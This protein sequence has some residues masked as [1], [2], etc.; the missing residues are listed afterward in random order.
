VCKVRAAI[1]A[2]KTVAAPVVRRERMDF[3]VNMEEKLG[4]ACGE[5]YRKEKKG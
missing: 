5:F 2:F 3:I 1:D 4:E